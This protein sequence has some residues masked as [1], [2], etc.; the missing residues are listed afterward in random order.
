M[1]PEIASVE[2]ST[3][4]C[5]DS[6]AD[7]RYEYMAGA[8]IISP[9]TPLAAGRDKKLKFE[10]GSTLRCYPARRNTGRISALRRRLPVEMPARG[11]R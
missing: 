6:R 2:A 10:S 9:R 5:S 8:K 1:T 7:Y 3:E 11:Y 4:L